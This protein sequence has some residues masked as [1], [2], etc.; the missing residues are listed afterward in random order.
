MA[1]HQLIFVYGFLPVMLLLYRMISPKIIR[2]YLLLVSVIFIAWGNP[3]DMIYLTAVI[4]FNYFSGKQLLQ[5]KT[6]GKKK[7]AGFVFV[8]SL[9]ADIGL[10][11]YFKYIGFFGG[12]FGAPDFNTGLAV[13]LG[14]SFV[15]FSL[16]SFLCDVYREK[17]EIRKLCFTDFALY[18]TFFP[19]ITSG[20][21]TGY[22]A[23]LDM[24]KGWNSKRERH[25]AGVE[26]FV[27]GLFKKTVIAGNLNLLFASLNTGAAHSAT[28]AWMLALCYTF[29]LYFDF[30]GYSDMAIGLAKMMGYQLPDN[31]DHPYASVGVADFWRRWHITLGRFFRDYVYIPLGGNRKG[32]ARK[33]LNQFIVFALTGL[34]HGANYTFIVW[35]LY[36]FVFITID[37]L[38]S[39]KLR[40][41]IPKTVFIILTF[42]EAMVGWVFFFSASIGQALGI[43][44]NMIGIG[45]VSGAGAYYLAS[46]GPLLVIAA[47]LSLPLAKNADRNLRKRYLW[48]E[49][50]RLIGLIVLLLVSTTAM[51]SDTYT[52]FL[53]A[54]F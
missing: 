16:I 12:M 47:L 38:I 30:S 5:L 45:T 28:E 26:R 2:A 14:I 13:P 22:N 48:Y 8:T 46:Y 7:T 24:L 25:N 9:I 10:L 37:G 35:G 53:Y 43:L 3:T 21:I 19:K 20:P 50:V 15:T 44:K 11:V 4:L 41:K 18:I 32:R 6:R 54:D 1:F 39:E 49:W 31:F 52:T 29:M 51:V 33:I 17:E 42:L 40:E 27:V 23:F 36:H 34:W